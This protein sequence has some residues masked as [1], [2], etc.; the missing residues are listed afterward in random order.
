MQRVCVVTGGSVGIGGACVEKFIAEGYQ[1]INLDIQS[2][3]L[4]EW[5]E[6]DVTNE[7]QVNQAINSVVSQWGRIDT[8]VCNAGIHF[9]GN[10]ESTSV[11]ALDR[12]LDINV[13]GAYFAIRASLPAMKDHNYG[14]IVLI[15][16]DQSTVAKQNSF[17]YNLSKF[18]IASMTKT[19]A[20]DYA[21]YG[22]CV[23]A[24]CPGT[25]ETPLFHNAI[26][27]YCQRTGADKKDVVQSEID[28][29]VMDRLGQPDEVAE[30][31][32]FLGSDKTGFITGS[33]H[34]IDGGY[35]AR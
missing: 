28:E 33:L 34:N 32:Y 8:L 24:V 22:I 25:I 6:C 17:A 26:D 15:G 10:I 29:Q 7:V 1:V 13:K 16:S 4:G 27:H 21:Q 5:I 12:V 20:L 14:R 35:T 2:G 11:E 31:V 3:P 9:S 18:A 23:N 30:L 19:T